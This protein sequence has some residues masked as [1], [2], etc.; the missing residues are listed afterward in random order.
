M[1]VVDQRLGR[2]IEIADETGATLDEVVA[3]I[4]RADHK[5]FAE[6]SASPSRLPLYMKSK[7]K[8]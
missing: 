1:K 4:G 3:A 5:T 2:M 6:V 8:P 7:V